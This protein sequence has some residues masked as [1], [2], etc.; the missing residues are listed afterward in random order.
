[1]AD[2]ETAPVTTTSPGQ[3]QQLSPKRWIALTV[4][5]VAAFMDMLDSTILNVTVP[6]IQRHLGSTYAQVQWI[7]AGYQ[8][9]FALLLILGGRLGDIYGRKR[10]FQLGVL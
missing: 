5:L 10:V 2:L 3:E 1:M 4:I 8:I 9:A 7:T 6:S